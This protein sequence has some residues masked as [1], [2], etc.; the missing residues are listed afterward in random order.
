MPTGTLAQEA[1]SKPTAMERMR[2]LRERQNEMSAEE[3]E[4]ER[5]AILQ[6]V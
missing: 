2:A 3:Y 5:K 6:D 4:A 1:S